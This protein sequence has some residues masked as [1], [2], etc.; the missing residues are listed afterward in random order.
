MKIVILRQITYEVTGQPMALITDK[1][2]DAGYH[3]QMTIVIQY[4]PPGKNLPIER[5]VSLKAYRKLKK[6]DA[7]TIFSEINEALEEIDVI[8]T[9]VVSL[10]LIHI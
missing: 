5:F 7:E 3:K 10:S 9:N 4:I 1:T 8:C 2:S 6:T